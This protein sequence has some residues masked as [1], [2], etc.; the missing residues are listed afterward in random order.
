MN[1]DIKNKKCK[2]SIKILKRKNK[3]LKY[4]KIGILFNYLISFIITLIFFIDLYNNFQD[5]QFIFL[6]IFILCLFIDF[7]IP[8]YGIIKKYRLFL[9]FTI[10]LNVSKVLYFEYLNYQF[11]IRNNTYTGDILLYILFTIYSTFLI[12]LYSINISK[13]KLA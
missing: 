12:I 4:I 11:K 5:F 1:Q 10:F 8:I 3:F 2:L 9:Y 6:C 13:Y 7:Y